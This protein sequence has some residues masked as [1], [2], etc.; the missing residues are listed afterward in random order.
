MSLHIEVDELLGAYALGAVSKREATA[1]REHVAGCL[2]CSANLERL[3]A[4]AAVLP[5]AVDQVEPPASLRRRVLADVNSEG[6]GKIISLPPPS[7]RG[8]GPTRIVSLRDIA[9]RRRRW[10]PGAAAA[11]VIVGLL[12]WNVMLQQ[13]I[14]RPAPATVAVATG[15]LTDARNARLGT[16]TYV[17][18]DQVALVSLH[19]LRTPSA[20]RIYELWLIGAGGHPQPAGRFTPEADGTKLLLVQH[21]MGPKDQIAVTEEPLAGSAAPTSNAIITGHI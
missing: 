14:S 11:A 6:P 16:I 20:G 5:L 4:V 3:V 18:R 7:R 12:S 19:S 1:V 13:Q 21:Q 9:W 2:E 15:S 10:L 17:A 8:E